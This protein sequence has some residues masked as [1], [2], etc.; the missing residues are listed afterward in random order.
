MTLFELIK[1]VEKDVTPILY[2][3]NYII[4]YNPGSIKLTIC[5]SDEED[6]WVTCDIANPILIPWYDCK[7][8][9]IY[10]SEDR[11]EV[12]LDGV[13]YLQDKYPATYFR[14]KELKVSIYH[15][16]D[17]VREVKDGT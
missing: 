13:K 16:T 14:E 8:T 1:L 6:F 4:C 15:D 12:W 17:S 9:C 3:G 2:E 7:V 10:P 11:L 5:L